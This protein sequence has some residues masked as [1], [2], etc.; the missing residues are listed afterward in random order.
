MAKKY[1]CL[2]LM[3]FCVLS[4]AIAQNQDTL[5]QKKN[6]YRFRFGGYGEILFQH[7]NYG[8]NRYNGPNGSPS[9]RRS[10]ISLPRAIFAFDYKFTPSLELSAEIEIENGGTGSA[11]ELE[12]EEAGEFKSAIEKGGEVVL[13][14]LSITKTFKPWLKL[15]VGHMIV[16]VGQI[17]A[18]HFPIQY[19]GA[20]RNEGE[21]AILPSTWHETGLAFLGRYKNW[22][23]ELQ[24]VNGLDANGFTSA[25]W[26]RSGRQ[27][28]FEKVKMTDPAFVMRLE[29]TSIKNL[30]L[31]VSGYYG[32]STGNIAEPRKMD[33]IKGT[34]SIGSFDF[35]FKN[36]KWIARGNVVYGNLSD[37]AEISRINKNVTKDIQFSRS[38]VAKNALTY[39]GELG[40]IL[41]LKGNRK[42]IPF[43]RYEYYNSMQAVESGQLADKRYKRTKLTVG[44]NYYLQPNLALKA[45]YSF[46]KID[47]GNY[48]NENTLSLALV[49]TGW[50]TKK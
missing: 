33:H 46:R 37:A 35:E 19:L 9:D 45:D 48:N 4:G 10:E 11:L 18:R 16:P 13:E 30:R 43:T 20:T 8:P 22:A 15:R 39:G 29:N 6:D 25:Y 32:N 5:T 49:Y 3:C 27:V 50:F 26:I 12:Y 42:I 44:A 28:K 2:F 17:N 14:Q 36:K 40:Y 21:V 38:P 23:Y 47:G 41:P 24:L 1:I 34:V 31:S 7:F